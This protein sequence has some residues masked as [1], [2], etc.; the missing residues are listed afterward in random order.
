M[1]HQFIM[2]S[3]TGMEWLKKQIK[4]LESTNSRFKKEI[5]KISNINPNTYNEFK[6]WTP[7]KLIFLNYVLGMY[8]PI[9]SSHFK[10]MF[11][12]DLFAGSGINK[13][14]KNKDTIM[15]SPFIAS[16]NYSNKFDKL[17]FVDLN[18]EYSKTL[19]NRLNSLPIKNKE[20]VN[21]DC[22]TSIDK[23]LEEIK[24]YR[25]KHT[26]FFIDPHSMEITWETMKKALSMR[27]DII[28]TFMT[29][30]IIRAW[31]GCIARG[32]CDT[33]KLDSFYGDKSWKKAKSSDDL[34]NIYEEKILKVRENG[35]LEHVHI[36]V[37]ERFN[38]HSIFITNKTKHGN[39][40]MNVIKKAKKE[41]EKNTEKAVKA[42]LDIIKK[43]QTQLSQFKGNI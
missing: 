36:N 1:P 39:P 16:L 30:Q 29:S 9:I 28:F 7:L 33:K 12:V 20:V 31:T 19:N 32:V 17:F 35:L 24:K 14:N 26:F 21:G 4:E 38:Y 43:R 40:W 37:G 6:E 3:L 34:L 2:Q 23:I 22:N 8:T 42:A 5:E 25:N 13:T 15:G 11:Y 41:I 18:K 27:S 10:N